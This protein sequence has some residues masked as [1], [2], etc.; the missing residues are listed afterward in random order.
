[1]I[2]QPNLVRLVVARKLPSIMY[3]SECTI[4]MIDTQLIYMCIIQIRSRVLLC[5]C[6]ALLVMGTM[7]ASWTDL[8][9]RVQMSSIYPDS[10]TF[11]DMPLKASK[12]KTWNLCHAHFL[13]IVLAT[14]AAIISSQLQ[15]ANLQR[16]IQGKKWLPIL[17]MLT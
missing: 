5:L 14:I 1:M 4:G 10:K 12:G 16:V 2:F 7:S 11:V 17:M 9:H 3:I 13:V 15:I 8:L 6:V